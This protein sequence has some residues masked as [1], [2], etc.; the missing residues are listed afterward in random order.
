MMT[1][2]DDGSGDLNKV[3]H[4]IVNDNKSA[5]YKL[6]LLRTLLR[7]ADAHS[8]AVIDRTDGKISLPMGL[9]ALYWVRQFKR[10]IDI[11]IEGTGDSAK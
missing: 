5:T 11:D 7:I 6:A 9:V 10:L 2:P 8:G 4:I 1:L 3:R